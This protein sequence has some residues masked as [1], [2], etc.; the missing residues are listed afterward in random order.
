MS[1]LLTSSAPIWA[2]DVG[3]LAVG[4]VHR[5]RLHA[6]AQ[7]GQR[8]ARRVAAIDD[9]DEIHIGEFL[10]RALLQGARYPAP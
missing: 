2:G 5:D 3:D 8:I 4:W 6:G 7:A 9:Q 10:A 1:D